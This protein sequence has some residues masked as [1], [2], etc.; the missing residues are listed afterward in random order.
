MT[1]RRRGLSDEEKALWDSVA[2]QADPLKKKRPQPQKPEPA[3]PAPR[4]GK[5]SAPVVAPDPMPKFRVG[6]TVD[7]H[8]MHDL[9]PSLTEQI[10][11][12]PIRM[13]Q[14]THKKMTKGK[15]TPEARID[16]HGMTLAEAHPELIHF[17]MTSQARGMRLVLVIT[18]KGKDRDRGGPIPTRFGVLKHQVPQWLR[19]AP[20][21]PSVLQVSQ[22]SLRH[23]GSG[24]YYVYLKRRR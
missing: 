16:L 2:R 12:D 5:P 7:H 10:G 1:R 9:L 24:A 3:T 8:G 14:K 4:P 11:R 6:Q 17:I 20:L 15:L 22:A 23:G 19:M 18:G 21:A 13:D